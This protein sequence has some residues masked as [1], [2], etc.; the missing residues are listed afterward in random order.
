MVYT[1]KITMNTL[2]QSGL[3]FSYSC[4]GAT[5]IPGATGSYEP[6]DELITPWFTLR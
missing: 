3:R 1:E 5:P 4:E 2:S 6:W